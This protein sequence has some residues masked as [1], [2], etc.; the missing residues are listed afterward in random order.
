[1]GTKS[2]SSIIKKALPA[3]V[4]I[5][6]TKSDDEEK[7]KNA[8]GRLIPISGPNGILTSKKKFG[9]VKTGSGSGFIVDS[10]GIIA[11]NR[12]VVSSFSS[13]YTVI[14]ND[15]RKFDAKVLAKDPVSDVA[16]LK[17]Q[18]KEVLPFLKLGDSSKIE[19]GDTAVAIGNALGVFRNTVSAGII[20]GLSRSIT[21]QIDSS[22]SQEIH[23]LIQT[24]AAINPGNSGGP[25]LDS[26]GEVVGINVAV[27]S[28]AENIGFAL[29]IDAVKKDLNDLKKYGRIRRPFLGIHYL[30]IDENV[31]EKFDLPISFG[32]LVKSEKPYSESV[33]LKSPADKAGIKEDDIILEVNSEKISSDKTINDILFNCEIGQNIKI[34]FIRKG[35]T[36]EKNI[37]LNERK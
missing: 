1:M 28:E 4:S 26:K 9:Y 31:K 18:A 23:G 29:P 24:D 2:L 3:V 32:A 33:I 11:S 34:K 7:T 20:S 19:L 21:A 13:R 6:V 14:M 17:I 35:K 8:L 10:S 25:L 5:T 27:I 30:I 37:L 12:H 36:F 16:L 15:N 22:S